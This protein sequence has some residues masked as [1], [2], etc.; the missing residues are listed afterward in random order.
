MTRSR[1]EKPALELAGSPV[2]GPIRD[3]EAWRTGR[4]GPT[5]TLRAVQL[6][7]GDHVEFHHCGGPDMTTRFSD[8]EKA[9]IL[10]RVVLLL[11]AVAAGLE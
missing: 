2:G 9:A 11:V 4:S 7:L 8:L 10:P 1:W 3:F 5:G 6:R